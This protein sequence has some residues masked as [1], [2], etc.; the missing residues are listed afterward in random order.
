M[1]IL[2]FKYLKIVLKYS[3]CKCI[4]NGLGYLPPLATTSITTAGPKQMTEKYRTEMQHDDSETEGK[5]LN[6]DSISGPCTG[7]VL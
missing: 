5:S 1:E 3:T 6:E 2:Q 4:V 7:Y